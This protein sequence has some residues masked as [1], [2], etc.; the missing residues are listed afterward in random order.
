MSLVPAVAASASPTYPVAAAGDSLT[1]AQA[2]SR[3]RLT[4]GSTVSV[5]DTAENIQKNLDALQAQAAR[6]T[7]LASTDGRQQLSVGAAQYARDGAILALWGA[8]SGNSVE[9]TGVSA[10]A[11]ASFVAGKPEWVGTITVADSITGIQRNLDALQTLVAAGSVRQI[12]HTTAASTLKIS[13][14]QLAANGDALAAIKNQ[15]YA[16]AITDASVADTLGL[17]GKSALVAN[18]RV[19]SIEVKDGTDAIEANLDALQRVGLRLKSIA[20]TDADNPM[21][22]T[23]AQVTKDAV[24]LGKILTS[25]Q[26]DVIRAT[27]AQAAKLAANQK[28]VTLAVAD[29]AANLSRKWALLQRLSDSLTSI[30]V[31][32]PGTALTLTGDQLALG[33]GLLAKFLDDGD[34]TY[35]LALS[36][37]KAGQAAGL[38]ALAHV[39]A[40]N[41]TDSA[42]NLVA[43]LDALATVNAAGLLQGITLSG[44]STV[45]TLDAARLQGDALAT[46]QGVLDRIGSG[47]Y[48]ISV[49]GAAVDRLADLAADPHVVAIEVAAS[50]AEIVSN[51]DALHQLG[52]RI[53]RIQQSDS[54]QALA[55]TQ[56]QFESRASVLARIDGGYAATLSGVAAAK[57]LPYALNNHI[58]GLDVADTGRNLAAHWA[59]LRSIGA[60]LTAVAKTDDGA[61]ALAATDYL[62]AQSD[63]LLDKLDGELTLSVLGASVAQAAD[64]AADDA[65]GQLSISDDGSAVAGAMTEL[66]TLLAGGKL[67]AITLNTGATSVAL[68]ASQLVEALDVLALV[69][70]GRYTLALDEVDVADVAL[71]LANTPKIARMKVQGDAAGIAARL[72]DLSAAG[73]RLVSLEQTDAADTALT[74][75]GADF[76]AYRTTLGKIVGG[77]QADLTGVAAA[78]AGTLAASTSVRSLQVSDSAA[79]LVAAWPA[80]GT[81]GAKLGGIEQTDAAL[82]QL[83]AAQWAA[84]SGVAAAFTTTLGVALSGVGVADLAALDG[85]DAVQE[86]EIRDQADTLADAWEALAADTRITGI[87][88]ADPGTALA[89]TATAWAAT[90][91]LQGR[92]LTDGW[93]AA[94]SDVAVGDAATLAGDA[95]VATLDVTGSGSEIGAAFADLAALSK[96]G[97]LTLSDDNGTLALTA[98]QVLGGG[99]TLARITNAYQVSASAA[100]VADL[101]LLQ[102]VDEVASVELSD[103]AANVA[104]SLD[105]LVALGSWVGAV[106]LSDDTPVLALTQSAWTTATALLGRIDGAW[107]A[108]LSDVEAA[109]T[110][111]LAAETSVRSL[112]VSDSA[113][114]VSANWDAL[115]AAY[116]DGSGKLTALS[117]NDAEALALS[118]QQQTDGAA[119]LAA[120]LPDASVVTSG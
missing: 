72:A 30:E 109:G 96:L 75:T 91:D 84:G 74:L 27:S 37:V 90:A 35:A 11:A 16:L 9:V 23:A 19:K 43:N 88:V 25:Y 112:S 33:D 50:S 47:R 38:A 56:A 63:G 52:R 41:V 101:A 107:Q 64:I 8:G 58:V 2:L 24:T 5:A 98:A 73:H 92:V 100:T 4:P 67:N 45:L 7:G 59:A 1:V 93:Q 36:G 71:L 86:I 26:L 13:A 39:S 120:L 113:A 40:L 110:A 85:Q 94:L 83:S 49:A 82:L 15:A 89:L 46:T 53:G 51:L 114:N 10:T 95:H 55:L 118:A 14:A 48:G 97:S 66:A 81:L 61:L 42:D 62:A 104:A 108:D 32:D 115:V 87:R 77:Y 57:A 28:V 3:L 102:G 99:D 80:L 65:V 103:S 20:Q 116:A 78:R 60:T 79:N 106:H 68:H 29:S 76:E 117:L 69:K 22:L 31:T 6:I 70:G 18:A 119:L 54:G 17:D 111:A 34:H 21:T 44:R 105:D 12:V